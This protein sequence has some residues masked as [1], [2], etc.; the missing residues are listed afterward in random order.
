MTWSAVAL[1]GAVPTLI[2]IF[3]TLA[4]FGNALCTNHV[5][6]TLAIMYVMDLVLSFQDSYLLYIIW[7]VIFSIGRSF[8]L[9][10]S[11]WTPWKDIYTRL[12]KRIYAKFL[13]KAESQVQA[14]SQT[15]RLNA[16]LLGLYRTATKY[17]IQ[18]YMFLLRLVSSTKMKWSNR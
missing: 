9:G 14:V 4:E 13:A 12:P 11:I 6:F 8:S 3:A 5:P 10:L 1:G 7:I 18:K 15:R 2:M 16:C 17:R